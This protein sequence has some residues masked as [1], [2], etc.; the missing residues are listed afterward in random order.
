MERSNYKS[1]EIDQYQDALGSDHFHYRKII[2]LGF[3]RKVRGFG[4]GKS[5]EEALTKS[6]GELVERS[7]FFKLAHQG[8]AKTSNGFACHPSQQTAMSKAECEIIERDIVMYHWLI[9]KS[10]YW[11][12]L[13]KDAPEVYANVVAD[14]K[15]FENHGMSIHFAIWGVVNN[16][17]VTVGTLRSINNEFGFC[18]ASSARKDFT[19]NIHSVIS[20]LRR[21]ATIIVAR[22]L[23]RLQ[24]FKE[25]TAENIS[26]PQDHREFYLNPIHLKNVEWFWNANPDINEYLV[27]SIRVELFK[28]DFSLPWDLNVA[29]AI[30]EEMQPYF[31]GVPILEKLNLKRLNNFNIE[32]DT[33]N[34]MPHPL[35]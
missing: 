22:R 4:S 11:F 33:I 23:E 9:Q 13:E 10:P 1:I 31:I 26:T 16:I 8:I 19:A 6:L 3:E 34:P 17:T 32:N 25:L 30:C 7:V 12:D 27:P 28:P 5:K 15:L 14:I 24:I 18:F 20:D 29:R 2:D 35:P 21:A